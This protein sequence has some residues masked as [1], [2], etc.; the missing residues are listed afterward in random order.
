MRRRAADGVKGAADVAAPLDEAQP[1]LAARRPGPAEEP[2]DRKLPTPAELA[3]ELLGGMVA[4]LQAPVGVGR[5]EGDPGDSRA[6][7]G[8][9][10]EGCRLICDPP[11]PTLL[12]AADQPADGVVVLDGCASGRKREPA[13]RAV[14]AAGDRPD[15]GRTAAR[16]ERR[17]DRR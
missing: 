16:A 5:N 17:D 1:A 12:P 3:R 9:D 4:A 15:G 10:D 11:Q 6:G 7:N 2:L 13:S 14:A 8:V